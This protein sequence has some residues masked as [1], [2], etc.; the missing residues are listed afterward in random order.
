M[1]L[2]QWWFIAI[3]YFFDA[4]FGSLS[5][6][7]EKK[8]STL[9][10]GLISFPM[11]FSVMVVNLMLYNPSESNSIVEKKE[12]VQDH[13]IDADNPNGLDNPD[14]P[15]P[16]GSQLR[17][18]MKLLRVIGYYLYWVWASLSGAYLYASSFSISDN[19][20][21]QLSTNARMLLAILIYCVV[22]N[23]E[24]NLL[25]LPIDTCILIKEKTK[26]H[27]NAI[28]Y[29]SRC[30]W[31]KCVGVILSYF[32]LIIFSFLFYLIL[33]TPTKDFFNQF[34]FMKNF[35]DLNLV[36]LICLTPNLYAAIVKGTLNTGEQLFEILIDQTPENNETTSNVHP[37]NMKC[38]TYGIFVVTLF[39]AASTT[40]I[41]HPASKGPYDDFMG[42]T[43]G[44]SQDL[45]DVLRFTV[46]TVMV[47][48][49]NLQN[50]G[51]SVRRLYSVRGNRPSN[52]IHL[53]Y[54]PV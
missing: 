3:L 44:K 41:M 25:G 42:K 38:H 16:C 47:T 19:S 26:K 46:T 36:T 43:L 31:L 10:A 52:A 6:I 20:F 39:A 24:V 21:V 48:A 8:Y 49:F 51:K 34:Y 1:K 27:M 30:G 15:S 18:L 14:T 50:V 28:D 53:A 5:Y 33:M 9:Q 4:F 45:I 7:L 17:S 2:L 37:K 12:I 22:A 23:A 13:L 40:S 54:Q 35:L 29:T 32:A 11:A